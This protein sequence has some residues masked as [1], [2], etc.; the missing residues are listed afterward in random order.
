MHLYVFDC[1]KSMGLP[2][3]K[4]SSESA[5]DLGL[6]YFRERVASDIITNRKTLYNGLVT[7][8]R[9]DPKFEET[10]DNTGVPDTQV[11]LPI[12]NVQYGEL[13]REKMDKVSPSFSNE[14]SIF[15]SLGAAIQLMDEFCG[16][17]KYDK[18]IVVV[19]DGEGNFKKPSGN[20]INELKKQKIHLKV[21]GI[22]F[23][24]DGNSPES[25]R[26]S[27]KIEIEREFRDICAELVE[28]DPANQ[29]VVVGSEEIIRSIQ[30]PRL[31][32]TRPVKVAD[33]DLVLGDDNVAEGRRFSFPVRLYPC[34]RKLQPQ[35]ATL[36]SEDKVGKLDQVQRSLQYY[37]PDPKYL[38]EDVERPSSPPPDIQDDDR[39]L[40]VDDS[41]LV[42]GYIYGHELVPVSDS[43]EIY[44]PTR[45]GFEIVG[46][47]ELQHGE[48][49]PFRLDRWLPMSTVDYC[50]PNTK[51]P[52][53]LKHWNARLLALR[54]DNMAYVA[55]LAIKE[56]SD[57]RMVVLAPYI[58]DS[59]VLLVID[60]PMAQDLRPYE[61]PSLLEPKNKAG[62]TLTGPDVLPSD[63]MY[64]LMGE[65]V[66]K[67]D[68]M[69]AEIGD[70]GEY[71]EYA[72]PFDVFHPLNSRIQQVLKHRAIAQPATVNEIPEKLPVQTKYQHPPSRM[73]SALSEQFSQLQKMLDLKEIERPS[74]LSAKR[75]SEKQEEKERMKARK[76]GLNVDDLL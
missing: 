61:F 59:V 43:T 17:R 14:R 21:L 56:T 58:E 70:E 7:A 33:L 26:S 8:K 28:N 12:K 32:K 67:M 53:T 68:L 39:F 34:T 40:P 76:T 24:E 69:T 73:I 37:R 2:H 19:T 55:R 60:L 57:P 35:S 64:Q 38:G 66:E 6:R 31:K 5:L 9:L 16:T 71:C 49:K 75:K 46:S 1:G 27:N 30:H 54:K 52:V 25:S 48:R 4:Y 23:E 20:S 65:V 42:P 72:D 74:T 50:I 62:K 45:T 36:V 3:N 22:G 10:Q 13:D 18:N 41:A 11:I 29:S 44:S 63:D 15:G 47:V 51:D